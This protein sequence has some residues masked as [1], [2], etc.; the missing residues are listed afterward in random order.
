MQMLA[1]LNELQ[2]QFRQRGWPP[3]HIGIG[4]NTGVM[5]V[6]NM[7]SEFRMAYTV[8]GDAV[9]LGSRLE[10]LTKN[11]GVQMIVSEFT[12]ASVPEYVYRELDIVRVKGKDKPVVIYEPVC[13]AGEED[14]VLQDELKLY[15]ET[16]KL[17]RAQNWDLAEM[18][19]INLQQ[20]YPQ[21]AL[22][23]MY[24]E[25]IAHYRQ[26]PPDADWDGVFTFQTK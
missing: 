25:R 10:G 15:R 6:G 13:A 4:L 14:K 21:R 16:L 1:R 18:Q 11:Y 2:A 7:G 8:M 12:K 3:I 17:Y 22:Y 19:F 26:N 24:M 5:T 23:A 20:M 9:N